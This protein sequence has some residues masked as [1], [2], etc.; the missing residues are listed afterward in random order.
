MADTIDKDTYDED[1]LNEFNSK[2]VTDEQTNQVKS[3]GN[4]DTSSQYSTSHGFDFDND[5]DINRMKKLV[6]FIPL[7]FDV[8]PSKGMFYP[9]GTSIS[10]KAATVKEIREFSSLDESVPKDVADK[11]NLILASCT[12]VFINN[13][14]ASY[15][16]ILEMDKFVVIMHIRA[17]TFEEGVSVIKIP[18]PSNACKT[19]GCVPQSTIN[20]DL[21]MFQ[22]KEPDDI[23]KK[24]YNQTE[25][26][27]TF[28][29]KNYGQVKMK[30]PTI[31]V[32]SA[33]TDWI[34]EQEKDKKKWDKIL[35]SLTTYF[36]KEWRGLTNDKIF[37]TAVTFE[38]WDTNKFTTI[39]RLAEKIDECS[40]IE[41]DLVTTCET[42]GGEI[43]VPAVFPDGFK[44]LF[45]PTISDISDELC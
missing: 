27:Y 45:V 30:P 20:L 17:L 37:Q 21:S 8:L 42:C 36:I 11:L 18:V 41:T 19:S 44:S 33:I 32:F 3:I 31:G 6:D 7:S 2:V 12:R 43:R 14:P 38:G 1:V 16:D 5:P 15:K 9:E 24:Y 29:L 22:F 39:Y 34:L 23:L 25:K 13:T 10:I 35:I 28:N 26:D 40:G 4:V